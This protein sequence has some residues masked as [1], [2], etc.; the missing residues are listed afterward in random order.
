MVAPIIAAAALGGLA[1]L[2]GGMM[3]NAAAEQASARQ[4]AFQKETLQ[5]GYQWATED[6]KK[7]GINPILAYK[8]GGAGS[9]PGASYSP[10]NVGAAAVQGA[11]QAT[12]SAKE[13][14]TLQTQLD[15]IKA[16]TKLKQSQDVTQHALTNQANANSALAAANTRNVDVL[17]LT[18]LEHLQSAKAAAARARA[19][20]E[21][22]ETDLGKAARQIGTIGREINILVPGGAPSRQ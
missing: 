21:I 15:N 13:A 22:L 12:S 14:S 5:H 4:M 20:Q 9:A 19:D 10:V 18:G 1:S 2:A 3:Q 17:T 8:Q 7:A 11:Q 16:D 6:M